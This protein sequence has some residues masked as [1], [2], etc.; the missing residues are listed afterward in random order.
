MQAIIVWTSLFS[1]KQ[2]ERNKPVALVEWNAG[3][4]DQTYDPYRLINR[5]TESKVGDGITSLTV[6]FRESCC[7]TYGFRPQV[8]FKDNKLFLLSYTGESPD[9]CACDC[10]FSIEYRIVGLPAAGYET[11]FHEKKIEISNDHYK[12]VKPTSELYNGQE[13][14][15][16]NRYGFKEGRWMTFFKDGGIE[17]IE[18]YR[19]RELYEEKSPLWRKVF[20]SSGRLSYFSRNDTTESWFADGTLKRRMATYTVGDTTYQKVFAL[21][22]NRRLYKRSL[23]RSYPSLSRSESKPKNE[24][25][26]IT[27][28]LYDEEYNTNGQLQRRVTKDT[29]YTWHGNGRI[30]SLEFG[31]GSIDYDEGGIVIERAFYWTIEGPVQWPALHH[32]LYADI[33][34]S[35]KVLKVHYVRE[36]LIQDGIVPGEHYYW[37]WNKAGKLIESPE[38]WEEPLPWKG[39]NQLTIP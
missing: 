7:A 14:N 9:S 31:N 29:T 27:Q 25:E 16:T 19:E 39:F 20:Y 30:A 8:D 17:A 12:V 38:N 36:E 32:S 26:S 21:H 33:G 1:C 22:D 4:C 18:M 3:Q 37:T 13:I 15:R 35:G 28:V 10:C 2:A 5:I 24:E 6:S 23:E 34:R 11:Y